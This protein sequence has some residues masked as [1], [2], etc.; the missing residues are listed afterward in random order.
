MN[1]SLRILIP[2]LLT[3]W[4][5]AEAFFPVVAA[6]A[7]GVLSDKY[8][9]GLVVRSCL[10]TLHTE[11]LIAGALLLV[12]LLAAEW[13]RAYGRTL[14]GPIL[15]TAAMLALTAFSQWN[16][17]P[18]MERDRLAAGGDIDKAA[19]ANPQRLDFERLHVASVRLE[20]GV[21]LAGIASVVFLSLSPRRRA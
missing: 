2:L 8:A 11:G 14:L 6:S 21:L 12:L 9:A 5:G 16:V 10:L 18:R 15:C 7:F 17:V 19:T 20:G 3:L 13:T 1:A 4:V